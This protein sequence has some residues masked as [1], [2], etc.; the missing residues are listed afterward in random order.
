MMKTAEKIFHETRELGLVALA[1]IN[2][3]SININKC[4]G[5]LSVLHAADVFDL[6]IQARSVQEIWQLLLGENPSQQKPHVDGIAYKKRRKNGSLAGW[7]E[8]SAYQWS[9]IG[10][11]PTRLQIFE[12][13]GLI[14]EAIQCYGCPPDENVTYLTSLNFIYTIIDP[15]INKC[16]NL[17]A[18]DYC[19][20]YDENQ[21]ADAN[22]AYWGFIVNCLV[23]NEVHFLVSPRLAQ[24]VDYWW[25]PIK[26]QQ[27]YEYYVSVKTNSV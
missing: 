6:L 19:Q 8:K 26:A 3:A 11:T 2:N 10:I 24:N 21:A 16:W 23:Q 4:M 14:R 1:H 17:F 7:N 15:F 18:V 13:F 12:E 9:I 22:T 25:N 27:S 5:L 20:D